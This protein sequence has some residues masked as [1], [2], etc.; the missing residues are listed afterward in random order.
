LYITDPRGWSIG[1]HPNGTIVIPQIPDAFYTGP[2]SEPER[3]IIP[4]PINGTYEILI[5][6]TGNGTYG[7]MVDF[8]FSMN[9]SERTKDVYYGSIVEGGV[10]WTKVIVSG[11]E[12]KSYTPVSTLGDINQDALVD[13]VDIVTCALA[14]GSETQ[15]NP[16]TP[17]D[18]TENWNPLTDLDLNKI[19]DIVDLVKIAIHFGQTV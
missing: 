13:I 8:A 5:A 1:T 10:L 14:Y 12:V 9:L 15:D 3:I 19:I 17:W 2:N 4:N 16:E 6:G 7:F 11:K 18:E